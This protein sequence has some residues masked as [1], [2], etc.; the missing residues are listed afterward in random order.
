V[1]EPR[2]RRSDRRLR[3]ARKPLGAEPVRVPASGTAG[4]FHECIAVSKTSNPAGAYWSYDYL[5][6]TTLFNDYPKIGVWPDGYYLSFNDFTDSGFEGVTVAA[7]P[8]VPLLSGLKQNGVEFTPSRYAAGP[9]SYSML[10]ADFDGRLQPPAGSP[11]IF[12]EYQTPPTS[13]SERVTLFALHA[14]YTTPSASTFAPIAGL[15]TA[16][17]TDQF[18]PQDCIRQKGMGVGLDDESDRLMQ[19]LAYR[20]YGGG[21]EALVLNHTVRGPKNDADG[22]PTAAVRWYELR[23]HSG[24]WSIYQQS[25]FQPDASASYPLSRW[26]GSAAMDGTHDLA[27]GSSAS[28]HLAYP[29]IRYAGRTPADAL[30]KLEGETTMWAGTGAQT[31]ADRWGD[32]T[33]MSIDPADDCTFWYLGEYYTATQGGDWHTRIGSFRFPNCV[34]ISSVSPG[35]GARGSTITI[36]G[37]GFTSTAVVKFNGVSASKTFVSSH[38]LKAVVPSTQGA[39]TVYS[40]ASFL[41]TG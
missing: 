29:S 12:A 31:E 37:V 3:L 26:M 25:T 13:A 34:G 14:N 28:S 19:R 23:K 36:N 33:A 11:E 8:R 10:P 16:P 7:L 2:R 32:Y 20:K 41:V 5:I 18:C 9:T 21:V 38:Q 17:F 4:G 30:G 24:I 39:N 40:P 27:V 35:S 1:P 22:K 6:S 15:A